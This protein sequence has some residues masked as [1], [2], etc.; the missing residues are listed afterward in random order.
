MIRPCKLIVSAS[1]S[2]TA[3]M[4]MGF[5]DVAIADPYTDEVAAFYQL[6]A[7]CDPAGENKCIGDSENALGAPSPSTG[8]FT[9][10]SLGGGFITLNFADNFCLEKTG[11]DL[12]VFDTNVREAFNLSVAD[13]SG[14]DYGPILAVPLFNPGFLP[15]GV[16][17]HQFDL[18]RLAPAGF[19]MQVRID[20]QTTGP[21]A[22]RF[23]GIDLDSVQCLHSVDI[24][25]TAEIGGIAGRGDGFGGG[26]AP[27]WNFSGSIA[28]G[29][30]PSDGI[31]VALGEIMINYRFLTGPVNCAFAPDDMSMTTLVNH[32]SA[33]LTD[34]TFDCEGSYLGR[35]N[36]GLQQG[37]AVTLNGTIE[38][39]V[40]MGST[41]FDINDS[42]GPLP[43]ET[44]NIQ[45]VGNV[46]AAV[47]P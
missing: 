34:W 30:D 32:M 44:G 17:E 12:I 7:N 28:A 23:V 24:D 26:E 35:A 27:L 39:A 3:G 22:N 38:V 9:I 1:A 11:N 16:F 31:A 29:Q 2:V 43:L 33:T 10:V 5:T 19:F 18:N 36:I 42:P 40:T 45:I 13:F 8:P 15:Q 25:W 47:S 14:R 20:D 4:M 6:D 21:Q 46:T 41:D 37:D